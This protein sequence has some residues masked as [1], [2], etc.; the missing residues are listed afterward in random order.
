MEVLELGKKIVQELNNDRSADTLTKWMAHYV[1]EKI[2]KAEQANSDNKEELKKEC[3]DIIL[4]IWEHR[5]S[6]NWNKPFKSYDEIFSLLNYF[7]G[8]TGYR[9]PTKE[10]N[11]DSEED[12]AECKKFAISVT[13]AA[14]VMIRFSIANASMSAAEKDNW[15]AENI[16]EFLCRDDDTILVRFLSNESK[17]LL[18]DN[19]NAIA[20][21]QK[22]LKSIQ[23]NLDFFIK[24]SEAFKKSLH[25]EKNK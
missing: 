25:E 2:Q 14:R 17:A 13:E 20:E 22:E 4:K 1:A 16:P 19:E 9:S 10:S 12:I 24:V 11:L 7:L 5:A 6:I 3:F 8:S 15:V 23:K 21:K 18:S